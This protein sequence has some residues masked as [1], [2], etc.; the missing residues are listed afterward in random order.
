M[1]VLV[2]IIR[3]NQMIISNGQSK[4]QHVSLKLTKE[5]ISNQKEKLH[6]VTSFGSRI[7]PSSD[8]SITQKSQ[9]NNNYRKWSHIHTIHSSGESWYRVRHYF[10]TIEPSNVL[11]ISWQLEVCP[12]PPP[13]KG[14]HNYYFRLS[15]LLF[16]TSGAH[17][18]HHLS[19]LLQGRIT[20]TFS[21]PPA[22]GAHDSHLRR[23]EER[24]E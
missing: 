8:I 7:E 3:I 11:K 21:F 2:T 4:S 24:W 1:Y 10:C 19:P 16:L 12:L 5:Y 14:A 9:D 22:S 20:H 13:Y 23:G 6:N 18:S 17:D 15:S